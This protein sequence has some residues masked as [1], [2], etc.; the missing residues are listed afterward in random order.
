MWM[1]LAH[2]YRYCCSCS[3]EGRAKLGK[4]RCN[5]TRHGG[6]T[7]EKLKKLA[8]A[9]TSNLLWQTPETAATSE[10]SGKSGSGFTTRRRHRSHS[11]TLA[12]QTASN[13]TP[14]STNFFFRATQNCGR[15]QRLA[16]PVGNRLKEWAKGSRSRTPRN[17]GHDILTGLPAT[18]SRHENTTYPCYGF[19]ADDTGSHCAASTE[20]TAKRR[21]R[22]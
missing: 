8:E 14:Q 17:I 20:P 5:A 7:V 6:S 12:M 18:D 9:T 10:I 2:R 4:K 19:P 22:P 15:F 13:P 1:L 16:W 3:S 11:R 21:N